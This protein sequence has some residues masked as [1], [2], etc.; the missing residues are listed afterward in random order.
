MQQKKIDDD[1]SK[2]LI[3]KKHINLINCSKANLSLRSQ[4]IYDSLLVSAVDALAAGHTGEWFT[5][6]SAQLREIMKIKKI[7]ESEITESL[8]SL[9]ST[10]YVSVRIREDIEEWSGSNLVSEWSFKKRRSTTDLIEAKFKLPDMIRDSI[11]RPQIYANLN[12]GVMN[13]YKS[14]YA[15][16]LH[17]FLKANFFDYNFSKIIT[18]KE[19]RMILGIPTDAFAGRN[20]NLINTCLKKP[21]K[22]IQEKNSDLH[23]I[24]YRIIRKGR[25]IKGIEF[26]K[27]RRDV[28]IPSSI[29]GFDQLIHKFKFKDSAIK[30]LLEKYSD[31]RIYAVLQYTYK[32][33]LKRKD[34]PAAIQDLKAYSIQLLT[35][36]ADV[37]STSIETNDKEVKELK[38]IRTQLNKHDLEVIQELMVEHSELLSRKVEDYLASLTEPEKEQLLKSLDS[39]QQESLF[40]L[41]WDAA[42]GFSNPIAKSYIVDKVKQDYIEQDIVDFANYVFNKTGRRVLSNSAGKYIFEEESIVDK[43]PGFTGEFLEEYLEKFKMATAK[44]FIQTTIAEKYI[45]ELQEDTSKGDEN[46][47][48]KLLIQGTLF[49]FTLKDLLEAKHIT[50]EEKNKKLTFQSNSQPFFDLDSLIPQ[51]PIDAL[52]V[53]M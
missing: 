7:R 16:A 2:E 1:V 21:L 39:E 11:A 14:K 20:D 30:A 19:M 25:R 36:D 32:Q 27:E 48:C 52:S 40:D 18:L 33:Y 17:P 37:D 47:L 10:P 50:I 45:Q 43:E 6:D 26:G 8:Q 49:S 15:Y 9:N 44:L 46:E 51:T 38:K 23:D 28:I 53:L 22:E 31:E 24:E 3:L 29:I 13:N 4:K 35:R 34:T 5:I 41:D 42:D 12:L